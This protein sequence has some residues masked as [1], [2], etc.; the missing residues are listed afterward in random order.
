VRAVL[1][2]KLDSI[3]RILGLSSWP[4]V[5]DQATATAVLDG[6][7][8]YETPSLVRRERL[9]QRVRQLDA[10]TA[11]A[12]D[13]GVVKNSGTITLGISQDD[14]GHLARTI[15]GETADWSRLRA[16]VLTTWSPRYP[17]SSRCARRM[18][19]MRCRRPGDSGNPHDLGGMMPILLFAD[20]ALTWIPHTYTGNA[21]SY[22]KTLLPVSW[23]KA[24][25]V[26]LRPWTSRRPRTSSSRR[27]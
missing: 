18:S 3:R 4:V 10:S 13:A 1:A 14:L 26:F 2:A 21:R 27:R 9:L 23:N 6:S 25:Y 12:R 20:N 16:L 24:D 22:K 19:G 7:L 15:V 5:L 17:R 11:A 8:E